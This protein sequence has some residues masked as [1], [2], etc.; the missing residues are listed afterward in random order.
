MYCNNNPVMYVDENGNFSLRDAWNKIKN[1]FKKNIGT[2][3]TYE[4]TNIEE[5]YFFIDYSNGTGISYS[6]QKPINLISIVPETWWEIWDYSVGIDFYKDGSGFQFFIGTDVGISWYGE[7]GGG[8]ISFDGS[9]RLKFS[10]IVDVPNS[11]Y[12]NLNELEINTHNIVGTIMV[13]KYCPKAA[14]V[15]GNLV[16]RLVTQG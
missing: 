13:C 7:Y 8:G 15:I 5:Y 16:Y 10:S 14:F 11:D 2:G 9:G 4:D 3:I 12:Y 1:W 6:D